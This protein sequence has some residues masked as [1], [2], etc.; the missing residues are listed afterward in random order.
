M[1]TDCSTLAKHRVWCSTITMEGGSHGC[2]RRAPQVGSDRWIGPPQH[3]TVGEIYPA[4]DPIAVDNTHEATHDGED[5]GNLLN[6][7]THQQETPR[8]AIRDIHL[9][10]SVEIIQNPMRPQHVITV[11]SEIGTVTSP[12]SPTKLM[13]LAPPHLAIDF[14]QRRLLCRRQL[15]S[16]RCLHLRPMIACFVHPPVTASAC[17]DSARRRRHPLPPSTTSAR[18]PLLF[19]PTTTIIR[20]KSAATLARRRG[21]DTITAAHADDRPRAALK[22]P[23]SLQCRHDCYSGKYCL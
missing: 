19:H 23:S 6:G 16:P 11:D 8:Q 22:T 15:P 12:S 14:C 10:G 1:C 4:P 21:R 5:D 3:I 20:S 18:P 2:R 17:R 13:L 9:V 7:E